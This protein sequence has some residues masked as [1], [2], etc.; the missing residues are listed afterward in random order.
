MP[1]IRDLMRG[2]GLL[3][4]EDLSISDAKLQI[5]VTTG[6]DSHEYTMNGDRIAVAH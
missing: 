5:G 1:N 4:V 2:E 6:V 3:E